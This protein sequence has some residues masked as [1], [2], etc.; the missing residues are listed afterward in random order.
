MVWCDVGRD[1]GLL[2]LITLSKVLSITF[3]NL[4]IHAKTLLLFKPSAPSTCCRFEVS[5]LANV[6][7]VQYAEHAF[8]EICNSYLIFQQLATTKTLDA[9]ETQMP[10]E[11]NRVTLLADKQT[12]LDMS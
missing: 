7:A 3:P 9:D 2:L 11:A 1:G 6:R 4:C 5:Q 10:H 12:W 8:V